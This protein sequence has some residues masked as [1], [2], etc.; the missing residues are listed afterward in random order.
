MYLSNESETQRLQSIGR[1]L[2]PGIPELLRQCE[3]QMAL[4]SGNHLRL[5]PECFRHPRQALLAL[6]EHLPLCPTSQDHSVVDAVA[7]VIAN[8]NS[9]ATSLPTIFGSDQS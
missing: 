7:F 5:L 8:Q 4:A 9:R 1:L 3:E 6:L 2:G